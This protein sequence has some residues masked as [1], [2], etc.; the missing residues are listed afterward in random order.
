ATRHRHDAVVAY[1]E[2]GPL[3]DL[4]GTALLPES[5]PELAGDDRLGGA[6]GVPQA[7]R[8]DRQPQQVQ[9]RD[10]EPEEQ[11]ERTP[12][13]KSER[14]TEA[15]RCGDRRRLCFRRVVGERL[16]LRGLSPW[17]R[18]IFLTLDLDCLKLFPIRS[19]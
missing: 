14:P 18:S 12:I 10:G 5:F 1:Q 13:G 4:Q 16:R 9:S 2:A 11:N 15:A 7:S 6:H 8:A 17:V 3:V 19:Q